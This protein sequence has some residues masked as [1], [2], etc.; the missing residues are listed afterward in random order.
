MSSSPKPAVGAPA[1]EPL[2]THAFPYDVIEADP[3]PS[4][5]PRQSSQAESAIAGETLARLQGKQEGQAEALRAF[6]ERLARERTVLVDVLSHFSRERAQY[7]KKVEAEVVQ[8]ALSIARKILHRES[9]TDPLLLAGI[10]RVALDN[11]N[12]ATHVVLRVN[13]AHAAEWKKFLAQHL[14]PASLPEIAEDASQPMD[15]C[16]LETAMGSAQ[17]G[18]EVQLK[19]IE[20]GLMDL[21]ASRPGG[22]G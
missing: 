6:E 12:G 18:L 1:T 3:P 10:V 13:P 21:L 14:Q 8:L 11:I 7:F 16:V 9:Q 2:H 15:Q 20:Q 22:A 17:M 19:E 5:S 4:S